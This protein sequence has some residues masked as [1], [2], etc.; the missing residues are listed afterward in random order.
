VS[1]RDAHEEARERWGLATVEKQAKQRAEGAALLRQVADQVEK[2]DVE[3]YMLA[4][5]FRPVEGY[6]R[7]G[8]IVGK[9]TSDRFIDV[10]AGAPQ[11]LDERRRHFVDRDRHV[12]DCDECWAHNYPGTERPK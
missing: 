4:R 6:R 8:T 10:F 1:H 11:R 3:G 5:V 7:S 12:E 2:G 9:Y